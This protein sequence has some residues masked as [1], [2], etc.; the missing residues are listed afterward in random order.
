MNFPYRLWTFT[1]NTK[2]PNDSNESGNFQN[3]LEICNYN[4]LK[5]LTKN[6]E[7]KTKERVEFGFTKIRQVL[8]HF[9]NDE[10]LP[11]R[12]N[13]S[14]P[15]FRKEITI[16]NETGR[17]YQKNTARFHVSVFF[18]KNVKAI[19]VVQVYK[20]LSIPHLGTFFGLTLPPSGL[21]LENPPPR[22][23]VPYLFTHTPSKKMCQYVCSHV[24]K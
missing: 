8:G 15:C 17:R 7:I 3:S 24:N 6:L 16:R 10:A 11:L 20:A 9:H 1:R 19:R 23:F 2:N 21:W 13:C 14:V 12:C 4:H 18:H 22:N 5:N